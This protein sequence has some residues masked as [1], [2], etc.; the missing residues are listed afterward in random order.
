MSSLDQKFQDAIWI[1]KALFDRDKATGLSA[2]LS[3]LHDDKIYITGNGT[4][5]G[6]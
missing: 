1:A 6:N 4:F 2:N 3:F 5:F